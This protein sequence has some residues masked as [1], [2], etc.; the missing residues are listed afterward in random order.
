MVYPQKPFRAYVPRRFA[1]RQEEYVEGQMRF[2]VPTESTAS[3]SLLTPRVH[4][5][6][7]LQL[8]WQP[9]N[10]IKRNASTR[11]HARVYRVYDG[12]KRRNINEN[13]TYGGNS[14]T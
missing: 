12:E 14:T 7:S 5:D 11:F 3:S 8:P 10:A 2:P 6:A 9:R 13:S 4:G 1:C